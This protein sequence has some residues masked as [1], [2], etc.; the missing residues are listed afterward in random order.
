MSVTPPGRF[1]RDRRGGWLKR[2]TGCPRLLPAPICSSWRTGVKRRMPI[3]GAC[4]LDK[5]HAERLAR[6]TGFRNIAI[7]HHRGL[8]ALKRDECC[9]C[10]VAA[11]PAFGLFPLSSSD[12]AGVDTGPTQTPTPANTALRVACCDCAVVATQR[13]EPQAP[14]LLSCGDH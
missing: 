2:A 14:G 9:D 12:T 8:F 10:A 13:A 4:R 7:R 1:W 6:M 3:A 11:T 5:R